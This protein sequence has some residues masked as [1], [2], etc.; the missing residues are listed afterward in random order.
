MRRQ[1]TFGLFALRG[2]LKTA[3]RR[4]RKHS[5]AGRR[6]LGKHDST[7]SA[8]VAQLSTNDPQLFTGAA[9]LVWSA[10]R[11]PPFLGLEISRILS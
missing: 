3:V 8:L 2:W 1:T 7:P 4:L 11:R 5:R 10:V 6:S 9:R